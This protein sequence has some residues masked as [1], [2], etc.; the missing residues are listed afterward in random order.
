MDLCSVFIRFRSLKLDAREVY[1]CKIQ[2]LNREKLRQF[3]LFLILN[4]SSSS[5]HKSIW[6]NRIY[7][8]PFNL[9]YTCLDSPKM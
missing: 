9:L 8:C 7:D 6:V 4:C 2:I 5:N 1:E 3:N